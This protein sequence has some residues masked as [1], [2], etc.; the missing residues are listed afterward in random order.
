L[1]GS[2]FQPLVLLLGAGGILLLG[3]LY[4]VQVRDHDVWAL[5]AARLVHSGREIPYRR[6]T[7]RDRNG[8]VLARDVDGYA[9][10]LVYRTFR[11]DH[12]LGQV[13]HALSLLEGRA[14][15]LEEVRFDL[16][17]KTLALARLSPRDWRAFAEGDR[18]TFAGRAVSATPDP[19]GE[20]RAR[21]A[22]DLSFYLRRIFDDKAGAW[23]RFVREA[24]ERRSDISLLDL[25]A[26]RRKRSAAEQERVLVERVRR[27][28]QQLERLSR[29]L[30]WAEPGEASGEPLPPPDP[31]D[32]IVYE[33]E[34]ARRSVE[35]AA[36][37]RLFREASGFS[38]GR[39]DAGLAS[40][41][42]DVSWIARRIGWDEGRTAAWIDGARA[43][44][45][46]SWRDRYALPPLV[47]SLALEPAAP[48]TEEELL[49]RLAILFGPDE[50]LGRALDGRV[51]SWRELGRLCVF[52][53]LEQVLAADVP[54]EARELMERVL[55]I[56][57]DVL[58][59]SPHGSPGLA[60]KTLISDEGRAQA[61]EIAQ[62][63]KENL[64]PEKLYM[65]HVEAIHAAS[66]A[67]LDDWERSFQEG[68]EVT[69]NAILADASPGELSE[70]GELR[71]GEENV[72][73]ALEQ[74]D[75]FLKDYG[76]R[77]RK[78]VPGDP[79]Y[80]VIYLL[81]HYRSEFPG[82]RIRR[83]CRRTRTEFDGGDPRPAEGILGAVSAVPL[84]SLLRQRG[85]A[86]ILRSL[87]RRPAR[88]DDEERELRRLISEVYLPD[89]LEGVSGVEGFFN[90][91][92]TGRNGYE[93]SLGLQNAE[94]GGLQRN[95][96][97]EAQ[98]GLDVRLTLDVELQAAAQRTLRHPEA[99]PADPKYDWGWHEEPVGAIT[100]VTL[101]GDVLVAASEP[102]EASVVGEAASGQRLQVI[103]RTFRKPTF[104]PPGS[105]FK[106]FVAA[107]ALERGLDPGT[108]VNC[109]PLSDG[110]AGYVDLHCWNEG[111]HGPVDLHMAL[112][113]SCNSYFAWLGESFSDAE[114]R[115]MGKLF[116]FGHPTGVGGQLPWDREDTRRTRLEDLGGFS[117][118]GGR[119][120]RLRDRERRMAGNGLGVIEATPMQVVRATLGLACG[121]LPSL[122]LAMEVG[123]QL[124]PLGEGRRL[125]VGADALAAVRK[126][127]S[128]VVSEANGTARS[129]LGPKALGLDIACKTGSADIRTSVEGEGRVVRKHTWVAGWVPAERPVAAFTIFEHDTRAT[130]SHGAIYLARQ[131]LQQPE[132]LSWLAEKGVDVS[133]ARAL[134]SGEEP[135]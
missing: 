94:G 25:V 120:V 109:A 99:V 117:R 101:D 7:I 43:S 76:M 28:L 135:R 110:R 123:D 125:G 111:G 30:P 13:A 11:R 113:R 2:R 88:T 89:E 124:L 116:G 100:L 45:L 96:V 50:G 126:A 128:G 127:L 3:R 122:R 55:P 8:A 14:V 37:S 129:A 77:P 87:K 63:L 118:R 54:D 62:L 35:D 119:F 61:G 40:Y 18:F 102:D 75:F 39:V 92:L 51:E 97:R 36:A 78:L 134:G 104:Q 98:D 53:R 107:Y 112:V 4:Q 115:E 60:A 26:G 15:S 103:E 73:R 106:P 85:D 108:R 69:F 91:E 49:D 48:H 114:F 81:E 44:W 65:R 52:E 9:L 20:L 17:R 32:R 83:E 42:L 12:P 19:A 31:L 47:W 57:L 6:G 5:E 34:R 130:S 121:E 95:S 80:D 74:A 1:I 84:P 67:I 29:L 58:R 59:D 23:K 56:Q 10:E 86:S 41:F 72:R 38:A 66:R 24:F 71:F 70:G 16:E 93:E 79:S 82:F 21:R 132:V 46:G 68:L 22:R 131:F 64:A 133:R 105:V 33:L 90:P 27:S